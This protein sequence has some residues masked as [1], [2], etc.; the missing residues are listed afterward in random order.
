[1]FG[2][3]FYQNPYPAWDKLRAINPVLH[4][5][6]VFGPLPAWL[7]TGYSAARETL[8]HPGIS[9]D[10]RRF[11]HIFDDA[12]MPDTLSAA[13]TGTMVATDPPDHTRLRRL[14]AK[15]F[16]Q[17]AIEQLRPRAEQI[18]SDLLDTM[19]PLGA[20]DL[21]AAFAS[22]LPVTIIGEPLGVPEADR[23]QLRTWSAASFN[24]EDPDSRRK[25]T[26]DLA[27]YMTGLI[28]TKQARPGDD[29]ITRLIAA[30][31]SGDQLTDTELLSLVIL[32]LI[33]G[34]ETT[35]TLIGNAV[36]ALLTNP[37]QLDFLRE[38]PDQ[39]PGAINELIRYD[40][41][42]AI[43]TIRFT[44]EPITINGV[45]IPANEIILVS[46]AG[47]NHDSAKY[48]DPDRLDLRRDASGHIGFGHG[49]HYCLGSQLAYM[50]T[51]IALCQLLQRLPDLRLATE[52][53]EL[54]WRH[55]R[56]IRGLETLPI[57]WD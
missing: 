47:A 29:L 32:L 56:L 36:H 25:A 45:D 44:A 8:A 54:R 20:T 18:T 4:V 50:E 6:G 34:H 40:G 21:I 23:T 13:V 3:S 10:V 33:A 17:N 1:V 15:A 53:T 30:R 55:T 57:R 24:E 28:I 38:H 43:A 22:P 51:E 48:S 46:P 49:I 39:V 11:Q 14:A 26:Y 5:P 2:A 41:P 16:T 7:I 19:A 42:V 37:A 52:E 9:K 35:T 27:A 12:G 31:D